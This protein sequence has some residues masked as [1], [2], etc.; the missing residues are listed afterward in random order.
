M[1]DTGT[2]NLDLKYLDPSQAQPE[3]KVNDAWDK[4][5]AAVGEGSG[6]AVSDLSSPPVVARALELKFMGA[7][8]THETGGVALIQIDSSSGGSPLTVTDG[9]H[10]VTDVTEIDF[11]FGG[12]VT[13][14]GGGVAQVYIDPVSGGSSGGG[15]ETPDSHP[16]VP[17]AM[18]DEFE[19]TTLDAKW[20]W[21][22]QNGATEAVAQGAV[23][24]VSD[25]TSSSPIVRGMELISQPL[26]SASSW[27]FRAKIGAWLTNNFNDFGLVLGESSSGKYLRAG[28]LYNAGALYNFEQYTAIGTVG[29]NYFQ[30]A[31]DGP[32]TL[33][34]VRPVYFEL[35]LASGT[36]HWRISDTGYEG[37]FI[38]IAS[39][40]MT[41]PFTVR[42]DSIGLFVE[43]IS[44]V[45]PAILWCDWFRRLA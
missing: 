22:N 8:V 15:N 24:M 7:T 3:V 42:P 33:T 25:L 36:I 30:A 6:I 23:H 13:D 9:V 39:V 29:T 18:D 37:S 5:D 35:E 32:V 26:A 16:L 19:G 10:T 21:V 43:A 1:S 4:I 2:P 38:E 14:L 31:Y 40:A 17:D 41:T 34:K 28:L 45:S 27:K 44:S 11:S 12:V 20:T